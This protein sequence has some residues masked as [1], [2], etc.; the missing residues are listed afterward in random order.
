[1]FEK[2]TSYGSEK[3]FGIVFSLVFLIIAGIQKN[4]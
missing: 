4:N 2:D 3:S 1:M